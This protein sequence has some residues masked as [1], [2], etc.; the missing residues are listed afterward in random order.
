MTRTELI[1]RVSAAA[2]L[3]ADQ[4]EKVMDSLVTVVTDAVGSKGSGFE[5]GMKLMGMYQSFIKK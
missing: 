2:E 4:V 3:P 1:K 5:K